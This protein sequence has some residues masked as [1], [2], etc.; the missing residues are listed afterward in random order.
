MAKSSTR[1]AAR[2]ARSR[3]FGVKITSG[4]RKLRRIWRRSRWKYCAGVV[5]FATWRLS[6]A[7]SWRKRSMRPLEC[8]GPLPSKPWGSSITSP[9]MRCHFTWA[10]VMNWSMITWAPF[11]KSP[12]CAS[13]MV[14][15]VGSARL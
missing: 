1:E 5:Q 10:E 4:V 11:A 6:S 12:N 15:V 8:S 2:G 14:S 7:Q 3:L 9:L 13:H